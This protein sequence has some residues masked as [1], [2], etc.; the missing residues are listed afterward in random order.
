[1]S[2][3]KRP[4]V[5]RIVPRAE[6][7]PQAMAGIIAAMRAEQKAYFAALPWWRRAWLKLRGW[8]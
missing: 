2:R 5:V 6:W 3:P 7:E 8:A 1:M 4:P